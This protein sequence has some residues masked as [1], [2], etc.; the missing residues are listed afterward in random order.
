MDLRQGK[1]PTTGRGRVRARGDQARPPGQARGALDQAGDR[2]RAVQGP[3]GRRA[4]EAARAAAPAAAPERSA[5]RDYETGQGP[6][7]SP[8]P[9]PP[10]A[11][12]PP[13][14]PKREPRKRRPSR[15]FPPGQAG[16]R[17]AAPPLRP[18]AC[19]ALPELRRTAGPRS[20]GA[21]DDRINRSCAPERRSRRDAWRLRRFPS[22]MW[23]N[24]EVLDFVGWLRD[25]E[26]TSH[27][28]HARLG[29][30]FDA[31]VHLDTPGRS[32][33]W[34]RRPAGARARCRRPSPARSDQPSAQRR[35]A[36][37]QRV[38]G[39][40]LFEAARRSA[41]AVAPARPGRAGRS[42]CSVRD[43]S[44]VSSSIRLRRAKERSAAS[45]RSARAARSPPRARRPA[46]L[47]DRVVAGVA[48]ELLAAVSE[49][50]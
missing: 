24:A 26:R 20:P 49:Q 23:R 37:L 12:A 34:R 3:P 47:P 41:R 1:R 13:S 42:C 18:P 2:H 8:G 39:A 19:G 7:A 29:D 31:V 48:Q 4:A 6:A 27:Y 11:A 50:K 36:V 44:R 28:F 40:H 10:A 22:W 45:C 43:S 9:A 30:Q 5:E 32:S 16:R 25:T 33:R 38:V 17:Q 15:P 46:A 14:G 35:G 21:G